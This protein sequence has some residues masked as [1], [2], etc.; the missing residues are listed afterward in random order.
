LFNAHHEDVDFVVPQDVADA[1]WGVALRTA[2]LSEQ[3]AAALE[4]E[5]YESG[6]K[7]SLPAR[8]MLVLHS[9]LD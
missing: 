4:I 1:T 5:S 2:P 7:I 8:S 9:P 3:D 6:D